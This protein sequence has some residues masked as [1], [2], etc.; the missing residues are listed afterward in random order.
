MLTLFT[1]ESKNAI[2]G[3]AAGTWYELAPGPDDG[4][5]WHSDSAYYWFDDWESVAEPILADRLLAYERHG[6]ACVEADDWA[7]PLSY[8]DDLCR[9]FRQADEPA[10]VHVVA[11]E[12]PLGLLQEIELGFPV[13]RDE[14]VRELESLASWCRTALV[15]WRCITVI[16][17]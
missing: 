1:L 14:L 10:L 2:Q 17:L 6:R 13:R 5:S 4:K 8:V 9:R 11:P 16:G 7:A 12:L 15:R 3:R